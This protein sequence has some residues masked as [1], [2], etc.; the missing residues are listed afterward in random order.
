MSES[1]DNEELM[2]TTTAG[3]KPGEKKTIQE[4]TALDAEDES[5]RKWKE[6]LGLGKAPVSATDDPRKV[7]VLQLALEVEGRP[8]VVLDLST[9]DAITKAK[10]EVI[11]IKEGIEYR[12]KVKF[13]VQHEVI[14]GLKFLQVVKR[15]GITVD[16]T[17][18]M[19]G[20]YGPS[21]EVYEKKFLAEQ[22]PSGLLT[23]GRYNAKSKFI[24][25]DKLTHMEW[26]WSFEIKKEWDN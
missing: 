23:R 2:P 5:L 1:F 16:K 22:A 6:N 17:E 18:E 19:I 13:R 12:L 20:S 24:D 14:S 8:D 26:A 15:K 10:N 25:D 3:Y 21:T 7:I 11:T 4:L 9:P